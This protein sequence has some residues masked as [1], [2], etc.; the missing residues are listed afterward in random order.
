MSPT[1]KKIICINVVIIAFLSIGYAF[2]YQ[3]WR[4]SLPTPKPA[5]LVQKP[6]GEV[7]ELPSTIQ[8]TAERPLHIH[9]Y[10]MGC[11]CSRFNLDHFRDLVLKYKSQVDFVVVLQGVDK[12]KALKRFTKYELGLPTV[13]DTERKI[14]KSLGVYS[15]PQA[16]IINTDG[17]LYYRGNYNKSRYCV[18]KPTQYARIALENLTAGLKRAPSAAFDKVAQTAYGCELPPNG[19]EVKDYK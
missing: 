5:D 3:D 6:I 7:I 16:V 19:I 12:E 8:R 1:I 18:D 14:A 2:W 10:N 9:F 13:F 11:P 17:T 15:T 4:Y